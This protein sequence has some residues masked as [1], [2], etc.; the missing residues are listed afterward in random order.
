MIVRDLTNQTF[1]RLVV[2]RPV[3]KARNGHYRWLCEC[4]C[5]NQVVVIK[6][7]LVNDVTKSCGCLATENREI[8]RLRYI[9]KT[10]RFELKAEMKKAGYL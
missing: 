10:R 4:E 3:K 5:G 9:E 8:L 7:N 1:G 6:N 2:I